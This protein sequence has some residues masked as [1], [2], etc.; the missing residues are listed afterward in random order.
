MHVLKVSLHVPRDLAGRERLADALRAELFAVR[1]DFNVSRGVVR[2]V[3]SK[4]Y[5]EDDLSL[6][7][8]KYEE[9]HPVNTEVCVVPL[10]RPTIVQLVGLFTLAVMVGLLFSKLGLLT[11]SV[12]VGSTVGFG[13]AF[14]LGLVAA[15]SSC[16]AVSGGLLLSATATFRERYGDRNFVGRTVPIASFIGGRLISYGG[17][18]AVIG[19]VGKTFI[20]SPWILGALTLVAAVYMI[21][22][23]LNMLQLTP[24]WLKRITPSTPKWITKRILDAEGKGGPL[25]PFVLGAATFFLPCGFTQAL[26]LYA[27]TTGSA[28]TS[29]LVLFAFALGTAPSLLALGWASTSLKG[30]AGQWF[31][32]FAGAVVILLGV[33]N[34]QNGLTIVGYPIIL[35]SFTVSTPVAQ[36]AADPNVTFDGKTQTINLSLTDSAPYYLPADHYTVR[37]GVPVK[38]T[39]NGQGGGCR[40]LFEIPKLGVQL[41]LTSAVNTTEFTPTQTGQ[42]VFSCSM[43]M[44]RGTLNIVPNT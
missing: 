10:E 16:I 9:Q 5:T 41:P 28:L 29:G 35:P 17:L 13:A 25:M 20:P 2:V 8:G 33:S 32:R 6:A 7:I 37:E 30:K 21:T 43:G 18:G 23:G 34:I 40:S 31:F 26:Q 39:V 11:P 4:P 38:L 1:V 44:Y 3:T 22:T 36:A 12:A 27:L 42:V 14:V 19:L 24:A 15:S